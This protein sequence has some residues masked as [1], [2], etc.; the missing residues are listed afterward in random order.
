LAGKPKW[1]AVTTLT[2]SNTFTGNITIFP[3]D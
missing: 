1:D 2:G 3:A